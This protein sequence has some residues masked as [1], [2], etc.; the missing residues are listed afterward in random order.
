[1]ILLGLLVGCLVALPA[2]TFAQ[3]KKYGIKAG[4]VTF[5]MLLK[6]SGREISKEKVVVYFDDFGLK[7]RKDTYQGETLKE[8]F[9]SDGKDLFKVIYA[10]KTAYKVGRASLGTELKV[11]WNSIPSKDKETGKAKKL[12]N[13]SIL[14]KDCECFE[15]VSGDTKT[16][17]AGW[18]GICL[19]TDSVSEKMQMQIT[20]QAIKF[21]EKPEVSPDTFKVL[22][23]F[24]L[25]E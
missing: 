13:I 2:E 15:L 10:E 23:G 14:G 22:A 16:R 21:E 7:E 6:M 18:N 20:L 8:S 24:A 17:F 25:K 9:F 5:D 4:I 19:L 11:D 12:A 1:M 3:V